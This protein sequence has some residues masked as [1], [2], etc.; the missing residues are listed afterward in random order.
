[1]IVFPPGEEF[2]AERA[3]VRFPVSVVGKPVVCRITVAALESR[4]GGGRDAGDALAAFRAHRGEVEARV[5]R[6]LLQ[7]QYEANRTILIGTG[8][9]ATR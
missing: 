2:D 8:D 1:M 7:G 3:E 5:R 4:Y 6:K 9:L